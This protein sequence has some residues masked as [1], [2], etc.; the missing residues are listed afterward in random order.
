[1]I[2]TTSFVSSSSSSLRCCNCCFY[3]HHRWTEKFLKRRGVRKTP[4]VRSRAKEEDDGAK[5]RILPPNAITLERVH[6]VL[7]AMAGEAP[8]EVTTS[9]QRKDLP[10]G[11][12]EEVDAKALKQ[13]STIQSAMR[14]TAD[15]WSRNG[16]QWREDVVDARSSSLR[17]IETS[18]NLTGKMK[19]IRKK[20]GDSGK[21]MSRTSWTKRTA[22]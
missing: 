14:V 7:D 11:E 21:Q 8:S 19:S 10:D 20:I 4:L 6:H 3:H 17:S 15:L 2:Q 22:A 18:S 1:M 9:K 16:V 13:S 5:D 12:D